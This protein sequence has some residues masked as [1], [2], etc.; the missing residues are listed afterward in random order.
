MIFCY[1]IINEDIN[2][3]KYVLSKIY[4]ILQLLILRMSQYMRVILRWIDIFD[5]KFADL[6][7]Q[8]IYLANTFLNDKG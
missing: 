8:K 6:L 2:L 4:I 5:I 3:F 1:A 7:L